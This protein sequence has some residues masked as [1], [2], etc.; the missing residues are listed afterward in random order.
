[1]D[2]QVSQEIIAGRRCPALKRLSCHGRMVR[3]RLGSAL[4]VFFLLTAYS[5][6]HAESAASRNNEG[7]RLFSKGRYADAERAYLD[8]QI[9]SPGKPEVLYNLGNSLVKQKNY[10]KGIQSLRQSINSGNSELKEQG[11]YNI[12][13]A[14]FSMGRFQDAAQAYIQALKLKPSDRDAKNNLE[15]AL[16]KLQQQNQQRSDPEQKPQ[17]SESRKPPQGQK[18]SPED[19]RSQNSQQSREKQQQA[20][21]QPKE[22][23]IS[24]EQAQQILDALQSRE[25]E[26]QRKL[27]EQR[28]RQK[29]NERDW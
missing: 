1:M 19:S 21:P 28:V 12:G 10:D 20:P 22:G 14:L 15:L 3:C 29:T 25:L 4:G 8:A 27:R 13:N 7:N 2:Q 6:I 9:K 17:N 24:K 11:W 26:E 5:N 23:S 18:K 16:L